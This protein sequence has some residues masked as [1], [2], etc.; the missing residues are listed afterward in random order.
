[1]P[2]QNPIDPGL[3][4]W[5]RIAT[6]EL[7]D[8]ARPRIRAEIE[9]HFA[10]AV[11]D[12]LA[13]G[14][15]REAAQAA[16][17]KALGNPF[18]AQAVFNRR[19]LTQTD[20]MLVRAFGGPACWGDRREWCQRLISVS[21]VISIIHLFVF[22][23]FDRLKMMKIAAVT[24]GFYLVTAL[25]L[26]MLYRIAPRRMGQSLRARLVVNGMAL[27]VIAVFAGILN[28]M[29]HPTATVGLSMAYLFL[30]LF[31]WG[32]VGRIISKLGKN[33]FDPIIPKDGPEGYA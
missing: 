27:T 30:I 32:M 7:C 5:L 4:R 15:S 6:C 20:L 25:A 1:M 23:F 29:I 13:Q 24:L 8:E 26:W 3:E 22:L 9:A 18:D 31:Y 33:S 12:A 21:I 14:R 16:A 10:E 19:S 11:E 28:Y 17:L 2:E